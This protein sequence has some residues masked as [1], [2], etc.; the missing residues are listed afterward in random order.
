MLNY[1]VTIETADPDVH[2]HKNRNYKNGNVIYGLEISGEDMPSI[3]KQADKYIER[4]LTYSYID[5]DSVPADMRATHEGR[6]IAAM[7]PQY[8]D[9]DTATHQVDMYCPW[10]NEGDLIKYV[11]TAYDTDFE[12]YERYR[13]VLRPI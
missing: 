4:M 1:K 11:Y 5:W 7:D 12:G 10:I 3:E 2:Y 8:K 9:Y 13:A 6:K